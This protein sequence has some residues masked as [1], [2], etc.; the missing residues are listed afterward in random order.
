MDIFE[1]ATQLKNQLSGMPWFVAVLAK[2]KLA[3]HRLV[4]LT[5]WQS[6]DIINSIP[7]KFENYQVLVHFANRKKDKVE[8]TSAAPE[9]ISEYAVSKETD[10]VKELTRLENICGTHTLCDLF[11][12]CHDGSNAVTNL[13]ERYPD[14]RKAMDRLYAEHGFEAINNELES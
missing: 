14:I 7:M 2:D 10:L 13:S 8:V 4:V 11:F 9:V 1:A 12:E 6:L 3:P 5:E